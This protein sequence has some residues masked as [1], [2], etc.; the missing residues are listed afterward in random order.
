MRYGYDVTAENIE[1]VT[2][3]L[4]RHFRPHGVTGQLDAE[5]LSVLGRLNALIAD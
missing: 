1:A 2:I 5:T 3:A 4:Q